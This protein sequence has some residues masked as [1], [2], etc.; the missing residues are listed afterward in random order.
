VIAGVGPDG[1]EASV[2]TAG[3]HVTDYV[4]DPCVHGKRSAHRLDAPDLV[5]EF[6][7]REPIGGNAIMEHAAGFHHGVSDL[8]SVAEA[9]QMPR[10]R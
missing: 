8:D 4:V 9:A 6:G 7:A 2:D 10:T 5:E 3:V 1:D